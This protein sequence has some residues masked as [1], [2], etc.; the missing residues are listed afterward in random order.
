MTEDERDD[1]SGE[2]TGAEVLGHHLAAAIRHDSHCAFVPRWSHRMYAADIRK[3]VR[4]LAEHGITSE[5]LQRLSRLPSGPIAAPGNSPQG[6]GSS[7]DSGGGTIVGAKVGVE[8][9]AELLSSIEA[10]TVEAGAQLGRALA[11]EVV[12]LRDD[13]ERIRTANL[14]LSSENR[15]LSEANSRMEKEVERLKDQNREGLPKEAEWAL[16]QVRAEADAF[17][18]V[19]EWTLDTIQS[20]LDEDSGC[21]KL[22]RS[23][24][25]CL[26]HHLARV[27]VLEGEVRGL[28]RA[29]DEREER[30][31]PPYRGGIAHD[32][33]AIRCSRH[34]GPRP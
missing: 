20:V 9:D 7:Q 17:R 10:G 16:M 3:A 14:Q 15:R 2:M 24:A 4:V 11:A 5:T 21:G 30:T 23:L 18:P 33:R 25:V 26:R 28:K 12:K 34:L 19:Q 1:V 6:D 22:S 8:I 13:W 32:P 29:L 31:S 27:R